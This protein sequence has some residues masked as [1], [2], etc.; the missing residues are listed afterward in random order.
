MRINSDFHKRLPMF[1]S[2]SDIR[3][4]KKRHVLGLIITNNESYFAATLYWHHKPVMSLG[5]MRES[6]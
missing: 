4:G 2:T 5:V 3:L 6:P 1:S